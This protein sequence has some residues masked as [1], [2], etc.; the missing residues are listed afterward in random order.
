M[1]ITIDQRFDERHS[2][3]AFNNYL[4]WLFLQF[5]RDNPEHSFCIHN[6]RC[7]KE[8][9]PANVSAAEHAN[10]RERSWLQGLFSK[11]RKGKEDL[12]IECFPSRQRITGS[13]P[14]IIIDLSML[15]HPGYFHKKEVRRFKKALS[16]LLSSSRPVIVL[17]RFYRQLLVEHFN[18]P[19][20]KIFLLSIQFP[21]E[22]L[23]LRFGEKE[24]IKMKYTNGLDYFFFAGDLHPRSELMTL[25]KAFSQFKHWQRTNMKLVIAV[26]KSNWSLVEFNKLLA[27]YKYRDDV[28]L[29]TDLTFTTLQ[30]LAGAAYCCIYP[31]RYDPLPWQVLVS[32][33]M[34]SPVICYDIPEIRDLAGEAVVYAEPG[35]SQ[36][37]SAMQRMYK[38]EGTRARIIEKAMIEFETQ[39]DNDTVFQNRLMAGKLIG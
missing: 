17:S 9:L 16:R 2:F 30:Q 26:Y 23:P 29:L 1:K 14:V 33:G 38:E 20:E 8:D 28:L 10:P 3:P 36:L 15:V 39:V 22:L 24:D 5:A 11:K 7:V 25:L 31:A 18:I 37:S 21:L 32:M 19:A 13:S 12:L 4:S 35:E 6:F 34:Q 27:T